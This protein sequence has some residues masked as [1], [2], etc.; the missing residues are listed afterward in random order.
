V[1]REPDNLKSQS[2]QVKDIP[3][4][5][6]SH[7]PCVVGNHWTVAGMNIEMIEFVHR[8]NVVTVTVRDCQF[9]RLV[10]DTTNDTT[11]ISE[12]HPGVENQGTVRPDDYID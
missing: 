7:V 5:D 11:E 6:L 8:P 4:L 3:V 9:E 12:G 10:S 2:T 1:T